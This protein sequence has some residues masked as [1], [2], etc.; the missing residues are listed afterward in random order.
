MPHVF[1]H[2]L[3]VDGGMNK[4][5]ETLTCLYREVRLRSLALFM[6]CLGSKE[7]PALAPS[8]PYDLGKLPD[9]VRP[10]WPQ[11][12]V[13]ERDVTLAGADERDLRWTVPGTRLHVAMDLDWLIVAADDVEVVVDDGVHVGRVFIE[14][15]RKRVRLVGGTYGQIELQIPG[16]LFPP[17]K[18]FH[19][20]WMI[21][22][23][24]LEGVHVESETDIPLL[25]RGR[26]IA[27]LQS[28][29][30]ARQCALWCS[31]TSPLMSEDLIVAGNRV[32]CGT[33]GTALRLDDVLRSVVVD[34][35][36]SPAASS[37]QFL[38]R[39]GVHFVGRNSFTVSVGGPTARTREAA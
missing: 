7:W 29:V 35:G 4:L 13:I 24:L 33:D 5:T 6:L 15:G 9:E 21:E 17:P 2:A 22:D 23:V 38:G 32:E 39:S 8:A 31:G 1:E 12:P 18:E 25:L 27:I 36:L 30:K 16:R 34:N 37:C 14:R 28:V 11:L 26:R 10:R 3:Q 19:E 20:R